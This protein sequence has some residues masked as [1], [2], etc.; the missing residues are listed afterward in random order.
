MQCEETLKASW[1]RAQHAGCPL[2]YIVG[3]C[4]TPPSLRTW[5]SPSAR[6]L[7][8]VISVSIASGWGVPLMIEE[9]ETTT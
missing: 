9:K 6:K 3:L 8:V 4:Q 2:A 1:H 7:T 5:D